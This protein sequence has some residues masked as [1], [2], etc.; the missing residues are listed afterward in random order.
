MNGINEESSGFSPPEEVKTYLDSIRTKHKSEFYGFSDDEIYQQVESDEKFSGMPRWKEYDDKRKSRGQYSGEDVTKPSFVN[1]LYHMLDYG[2]EEESSPML[3]AAYNRSLTGMT[4]QAVTGEA[5]YDLSD[6]EGTFA[7]EVGASFMSFLMPL[8]LLAM[9]SGGAL[10]TGRFGVGA[11]GVQLGKFKGI[12][13]MAKKG[14]ISRMTAMAK[15]KNLNPNIINGVA[16]SALMGINQGTT[17]MVYEGAM[18]GARGA[19][20][21][22]DL[23][24]ILSD[25]GHGMMHGA[26]MGGAAGMV[27]GGIASR[28]AFLYKQSV[29]PKHTLTKWE[30]IQKAASGNIGQIAAEASVFTAPEAGKLIVQG[31]G[32]ARELAM[33]FAHNIA[34]FGTMKLKHKLLKEG[35]DVLGEYL[36]K[37]LPSEKTTMDNISRSTEDLAKSMTE[38]FHDPANSPGTKRALEEHKID[39]EKFSKK[40]S[41][42]HKKLFNKELDPS[43][44]DPSRMQEEYNNFLKLII[45]CHRALS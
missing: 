25:V 12:S 43:E 8:D 17:L 23:K 30:R 26:L 3:R 15:T 20:E 13:G 37:I 22:K 4:E 27:G 35:K 41:E 45:T 39:I 5:R 1:S 33:T 40:V 14:M 2:I 10:A 11:V 24:G 21:G 29:N 16:N 36:E 18:G 38:E 34:L 44:L 19:V 6:Y 9:A 31:E 32:T 28:N 7:Q 42:K